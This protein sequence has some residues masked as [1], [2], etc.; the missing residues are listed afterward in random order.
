M[1]RGFYN[2]KKGINRD[3]IAWLHQPIDFS[4]SGILNWLKQNAEKA[5][6]DHHRLSL[7]CF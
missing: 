7:H 2:S 4:V 5:L 6:V 3:T 1:T